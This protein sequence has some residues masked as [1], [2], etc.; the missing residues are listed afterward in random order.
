MAQTR[1]RNKSNSNTGKIILGIIIF[2]LLGLF[3]KAC[4]GDTG[5]ARC[6]KCGAEFK[7]GTTEY[8]NVKLWHNG[9]CSHCASY[10]NKRIEA[11]DFINSNR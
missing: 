10:I 6:E 1:S 2:F 8:Y 7:S 3:S 9:Y 5:Y 4:D 11:E